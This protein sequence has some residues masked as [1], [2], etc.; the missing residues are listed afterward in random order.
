MLEPADL[1]ELDALSGESAKQHARQ[2]IERLSRQLKF[3]QTK[4]QAL[5]FE[6]ARLKQW[7]FGSSSESMDSAQAQL[8]DAKIEAAL[9]EE[10]KAED[11]GADEARKPAKAKRQAK[12]QALPSQLERIEHHYEIEPAVCALGH[13]LKRIGEEISEQ[14]DCVPAQFFVHRHIRGKYTCVCCQ[15]VMA[16]SMPAQIIDKGIPAAGLLAQVIIAKF[17]DHLPLFRQEEIYRRSGAT[18]PRSSMAGWVG[19][20]GVRLLPLVQAMTQ[21]LLAQGVLHGDETPVK[22][23]QPG[24]G[25]THQAY[26]WAWRTSDL[27]TGDKAVVFDFA[28]SRSGENARRMLQDYGGTLVVDDYSGYKATF[29]EGR[30]I[31]AGCWAHARRK[32]FEA[33]KLNHSEIAK[34]ALEWIAELY[35]IEREVKDLDEE[36]RLAIRRSRSKPLLVEFKAWLLAERVQLVKADVTARAMDYALRRWDALLV[37]VD[38]ARVPVDN[39]PVENVIRPIA[40]GRKN[41]LF[42]GSEQAG[43]R[44]A[45]LMSLIESAK[46]NGHDAWAY[47][48][49]V[50]TK[51]PT[52][53]IPA[54]RN[55]CPIAGWLLPL[56]DRFTSVN[57]G[58]PRAYSE[59]L[60]A[61]IQTCEFAGR[62]HSYLSA[63]K[64]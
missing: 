17:D 18:I 60:H 20:C 23:L 10:S 58:S 57:V 29:R 7:R 26:V 11:R 64:E 12:R 50:L 51:L 62:G 27:C 56:P 33:H 1:L 45:V 9:V 15:T 37:H 19:Q 49:D 5:N 41:W 30:V 32:F 46:L 38:D 14:L 16:A 42:I 24:L 53:P 61:L 28:K 48:K 34:Q 52:G 47:L 8:F 21:H 4:N 3:E 35:G 39:N 22:L 31:E 2:L 25:K 40:L 54:S 36:D 63:S 59:T 6:L 43:E 13:S 44:A 55:C